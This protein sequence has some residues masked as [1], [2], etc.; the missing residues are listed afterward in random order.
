MLLLFCYTETDATSNIKML[1]L[2]YGSED[3][4]TVDVVF[5]YDWA[6]YY[7]GEQ[8]VGGV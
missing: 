8:Q 3:L 7:R 2:D 4:L 1:N 5:R 6:N